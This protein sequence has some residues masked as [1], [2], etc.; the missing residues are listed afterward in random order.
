MLIFTAFF[1]ATAFGQ[2][3]LL[4]NNHFGNELG[5]F[6]NQ[7]EQTDDGGFIITGIHN[8]GGYPVPE[9]LYLVK[10]DAQGN[11]TW[12][13]TYGGEV[14]ATGHSV[15]QTDDGGYIITGIVDEGIYG[16]YGNLY[17]VKTDASG[18]S[19]WTHSFNWG[20]IDT[21]FEVVIDDD[22]GYVIAGVHD[23]GFTSPNGDMLLMKL[24]QNGNQVWMQTYDNAGRDC[25]YSMDK[26][27]DGGFILGGATREDPYGGYGEIYLLKTDSEGEMLWDRNFGDGTITSVKQAS[28]GGYILGGV[29]GRNYANMEDMFIIK[30]DSEGV[31]E[32]QKIWG[33]AYVEFGLSVI[34][35]A[36]GGYL[37]SGINH[38]IKFDSVGRIT[39]INEVPMQVSARNIQNTSDGNF[40]ITGSSLLQSYGMNDVSLLKIDD[41][42]ETMTVE[43]YPIESPTSVIPGGEFPYRIAIRNNTG[44]VYTIDL[45]LSIKTGIFNYF[46]LTFRYGLEI[47]PGETFQQRNVHQQIPA[48]TPTG[49]SAYKAAI[50]DVLTSE[51]LM[52]DVLPLTILPADNIS[53]ENPD[54]VFANDIESMPDNNILHPAYPNPFNPTTELKYDMKSSG[55][56]SLSVFDIAGKEVGK[57]VDG[58]QPAGQHNVIFD[59]S[60]LTSGVYFVRMNT[61]GFSETQK[62]LLLK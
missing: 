58:W 33:T 18:D 27:S 48:Q 19:L 7:V 14:S 44:V 22:G 53:G 50:F 51:L 29:T 35:T 17:I 43:L 20:E 62:I 6:G 39:G 52:E 60:E 5:D 24:D 49:S 46:D 21:G 2:P 4:F 40:I 30:T 26:T 55:N 16:L 56:V 34:E 37:L 9:Q 8:L 31:R 3:N 1:A 15:R 38:L 13:H 25:A 12:S 41:Q 57:L 11:F 47:E 36:D 54:G 32:W 10:T 28:D 61:T 42:L 23:G 45:V 59:G